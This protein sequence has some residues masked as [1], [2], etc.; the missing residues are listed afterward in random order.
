EGEGCIVHARSP[1][2]KLPRVTLSRCRPAATTEEAA[3]AGEKW[4]VSNFSPPATILAII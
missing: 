4:T 2:A 3:I 1:P